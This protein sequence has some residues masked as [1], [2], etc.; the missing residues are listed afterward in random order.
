[1]TQESVPNEEKPGA[2]WLSDDPEFKAAVKAAAKAEVAELLNGARPQ[3]E[4]GGDVNDI[5]RTLALSIAEISDQGT[6]RKRVAPEILARRDMARKDMIEL[7][8]E[9]R[10]AKA[11][12]EYALVAK[13]YLNERFVEPYRWGDNRKAEQVHI[14][15]NGVPNEAMRP[16]NDVAKKIYGK[17]RES[18]GSV[19]AK[20]IKGIDLRPMWITN[21]GL[22]VKGAISTRRQVGTIDHIE[23]GSADAPVFDDELAIVGAPRTIGAMID[24]SADSVNVLGTVAAPAKQHA[25]GGN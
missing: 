25:F 7:I 13:V 12:P 19:D 11:S 2:N 16:V 20:E 9:A 24:P 14:V 21:G 22:V 6:N 23:D 18:V 10:E 4:E 15:W 8:R 5:L 1:M 3:I 17:Y